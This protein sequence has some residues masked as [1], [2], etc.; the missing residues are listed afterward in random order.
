M[1]MASF[2]M[3]IVSKSR[4]RVVIERT[5]RRRICFA[6]EIYL[7]LFKIVRLPR[8]HDDPGQP[9]M[10]SARRQAAV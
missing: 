1:Q 4:R 6:I 10:A 9:I 3:S 7:M 5:S 2:S 8:H